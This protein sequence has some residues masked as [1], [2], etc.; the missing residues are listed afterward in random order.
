MSDLSCEITKIIGISPAINLWGKFYKYADNTGD[1][2]FERL[3]LWV[4]AELKWSDGSVQHRIFPVSQ[5][6]V[7]GINTDGCNPSVVDLLATE[8]FH[9]DQFEIFGISLK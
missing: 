2:Y 6:D 1:F 4:A 8:V 5:D 7:S 9:E 3:V